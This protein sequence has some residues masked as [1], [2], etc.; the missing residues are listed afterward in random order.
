MQMA[1]NVGD[2]RLIAQRRLPR[3]VF[4]YVDGGAEDEVTYG[5]N[6]RDFHNWEF[7]PAVLRDVS[8]IDTSSVLLGR[9]IPFPLILAPT[10]FTRIVDPP[11]EL[12]VARAAAARDIPYALSTLGTRSIEEVAE[13][14]AGGRNWFQVYV[15][16]DGVW[17]A[18]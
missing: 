5:R 3:G 9:K 2:L 7:S 15:W 8:N 16:K 13:A 18:T 6:E 14:G 10:G 11:G 12:S 17:S 4:D 1:A